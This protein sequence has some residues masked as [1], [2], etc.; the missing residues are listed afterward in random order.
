MGKRRY[1]D[2]LP[3]EANLPCY[4]PA[5]NRPGTYIITRTQGTMQSATTISSA[6][7]LAKSLDT[8]PAVAI[9]RLYANPQCA[10]LCPVDT[11]HLAAAGSIPAH[12]LS[13]MLPW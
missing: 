10:F 7:S 4:H 11:A 3:M 2:T 5:R 1:E 9:M 13:C 8:P 6:Q 12:L